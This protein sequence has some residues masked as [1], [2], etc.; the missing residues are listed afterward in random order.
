MTRS[1]VLRKLSRASEMT[2]SGWRRR[3]SNRLR[4]LSSGKV[5]PTTLSKK[6]ISYS[7]RFLRPKGRIR[8]SNWQ[9]QE[10]RRRRRARLSLQSYKCHKDKL[11]SNQ[12]IPS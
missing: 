6:E 9:L 7:S 10:S 2:K 4:A 1:T 12:V 11:M 8:Y 5:G 3:R